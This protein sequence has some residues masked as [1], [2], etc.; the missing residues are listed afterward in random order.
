M[1]WS[2][3]GSKKSA[4]LGKEIGLEV[5]PPSHYHEQ[6]SIFYSNPLEN[7]CHTIHAFDICLGG[8]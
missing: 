7:S 1:F 5:V 4:K 8:N 3:Y 6:V 2:A